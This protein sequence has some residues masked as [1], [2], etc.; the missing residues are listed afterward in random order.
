[1]MYLGDMQC[2]QCVKG[3]IRWLYRGEQEGKGTKR[4][5]QFNAFFHVA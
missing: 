2:S 3:V 4:E 5:S 1:V